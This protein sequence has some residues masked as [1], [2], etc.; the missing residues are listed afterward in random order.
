M[1]LVF[2][3]S[4]WTGAAIVYTH[5]DGAATYTVASD[6]LN[7]YDVAQAL[8]SWLD[9]GARPW[10]AHISGVTLTVAEDAAAKRMHATFAFAGSGPTFVSVVPNATW[11]AQFGDTSANPT[12][13][14]PAS[15]SCVVG[16]VMWERWDTQAGERSREG[17]WRAHGGD[18]AHR[19]PSCELGFASLGQVYAYGAALRLASQPRQARVYDEMA[20]VWRLVTVGRSEL[21][22]VA[23]D[24]T[25]VAG[26]LDILGGL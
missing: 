26:T 9:D 21:Q 11:I 25:L 10:A 2:T 16:T 20:D 1:P 5:A 23:D 13:S 19:R 6:A 12:G 17:A 24:A 22:H 7:A 8:R 3:T 15:C 14:M 18:N 4:G